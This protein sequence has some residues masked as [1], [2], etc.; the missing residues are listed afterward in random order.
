MNNNIDFN[1]PDDKS[2]EE[3]E[4]TKCP[5]CK[6]VIKHRYKEVMVDGITYYAHILC[7]EQSKLK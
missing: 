2:M 5:Y 3:E 1:P 6:R 4:V 7:Y